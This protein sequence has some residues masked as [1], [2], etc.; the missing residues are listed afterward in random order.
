MSQMNVRAKD[1]GTGGSRLLF[2]GYASVTE[3]PFEMY[4]WYGPYT[5]VVRQGAFAKTLNEGCDTAYL[6]NHGGVT[7]AR[8]TRGTLRLSEDDTGLYVEADLDPD[9]SDVGII[10]SA[11]RGGELDEMS[12]AFWITRGLWSPDYEQ[13]DI[14]EVSLDKGDVSIVNYGANP[15]TA[16]LVGLRSRQLA[17]LAR[18]S[19]PA[20]VR[21]AYKRR[22]GEYLAPGDLGAMLHI[23]G[24]A[25][26]SDDTP[27]ETRAILAQ[28]LGSKEERIAQ[29]TASGRT[30][31]GDPE[32]T[33]PA[34]PAARE[35]TDADTAMR[36]WVKARSAELREGKSLSAAT[37]E[38]L[39][40][41][42]D[43]VA[44]ADQAVDLAQPLL[45]DLMGVPN[46]D[47]DDAQ[48]PDG[49]EPDEGD[50][51]DVDDVQGTQQS[52]G[53]SLD[54]ATRQIE[55]LKLASPTRT[56]L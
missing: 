44:E 16:G 29:A 22:T 3:A 50:D 20:M 33:E 8:T 30:N 19:F 47:E 21:E 48:D 11:I 40:K 45:A 39:S 56:R 23:V 26:Q 43:L 24:L 5:E 4:D 27:D 13:Y 2:T 53:L 35:R 36:S 17:N 15:H 10:V 49:D 31:V 1:D 25:T 51:D 52:D 18:S 42:L 12:F 34:A 14:Q 46:P 41:V 38:V 7:M 9:R 32:P 55:A 6:T 28:I 54:L 37:M